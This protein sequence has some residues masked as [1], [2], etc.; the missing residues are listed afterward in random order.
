MSHKR[1]FPRV[2]VTVYAIY[3]YKGKSYSINEPQ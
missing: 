3:N 1:E 2:K